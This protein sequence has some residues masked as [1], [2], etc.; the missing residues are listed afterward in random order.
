MQKRNLLIIFS[1]FFGLLWLYNIVK[2][3]SVAFYWDEIYTYLH[4]VK[5]GNLI[6]HQLDKM[7]ANNHP[8]NTFL[9]YLCVKLFGH[10]LFVL[11]LPNIIAYLF[12]AF[13]AYRFAA[14]STTFLLS[15]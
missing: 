12:Y 13:F 15:I 7:D 3:Y 4:Y 9:I 10:H 14:K 2:A 5:K 1:V 8:L 6:P 11:R